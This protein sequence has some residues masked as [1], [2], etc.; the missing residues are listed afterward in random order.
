M[1]SLLLH[2]PT[3][4]ILNLLDVYNT[5]I[6]YIYIKEASFYGLTM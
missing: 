2:V 4:K 3:Y 5:Y 1:K 6:E